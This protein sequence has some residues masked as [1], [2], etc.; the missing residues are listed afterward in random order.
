MNTRRHATAL[1]NEIVSCKS[2]QAAGFVSKM[3]A[4]REGFW[5]GK[6]LRSVH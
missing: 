6:R 5:S 4:S 3:I 2:D 1:D